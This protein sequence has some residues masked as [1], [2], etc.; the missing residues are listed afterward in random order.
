MRT[1]GIAHHHVAAV[2]PRFDAVPRDRAETGGLIQCNGQGLGHARQSPGPADVRSSARPMRPAAALPLRSSP[3]SG[4]TS[5]T[6]GCPRVM[7]PVLS[8][9]TVSMW[10]AASSASPPLIRMP[11]SAP[12]SGSDHDRGGSGQAQRAR[13][14]DDQHSH[15]IHQ[16]ERERRKCQPHQEGQH[17]RWPARPR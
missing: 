15:E 1:G 9:M 14:G 3:S 16:R 11:R 17:A 2:D 13:A 10:Y 6:R 5:V 8:R 4:I 7:V 12:P